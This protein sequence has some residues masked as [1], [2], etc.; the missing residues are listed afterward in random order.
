MLVS[1]NKDAHV[2]TFMRSAVAE[3]V[4]LVDIGHSPNAVS[5]GGKEYKGTNEVQRWR[6]AVSGLRDALAG[7]ESTNASP[8]FEQLKAALPENFVEDISTFISVMTNNEVQYLAD[9]SSAE[10]RELNR[11]ISTVRGAVAGVNRLYSSIRYKT[12]EDLG[13]KTIADSKGKTANGKSVL[14]GAKKFFNSQ[15]LDFFSWGHEIG[16]SG[17][18]VNEM[19]SDGYFNNTVNRV[20]ETQ[21]FMESLYKKY[22]FTNKDATKWGKETHSIDLDSGEAINLSTT[23]IMELYALSFRTQAIHHIL[24]GGIKSET[25]GNDAAHPY[26]ITENDLDAMFELL[27]NEQKSIIDEMQEFMSTKAAAWGNEVTQRL[28]MYDAFNEDYYW[29]IRSADESHDTKDPDKARAFNAILNSSFTKQLTP[30]ATSPIQI[31][32]AFSTFVDHC[33]QM[34]NYNGLA[35]PLQDTL[36]WLN[37]KARNDDGTVN[38]DATV[39]TALNR[40]GNKEAETYIVEFIKDLNGI[41]AKPRNIALAEKLTANAK[42]AAIAAK[43]RVV[44]QQPTSVIRA[45]A[46]IDPKY[47][48]TTKQFGVK[49]AVKEM[50]TYAPIAWWKSN[51]NYEI[52]LGQS[53]RDMIMGDANTFDQVNNLLMKPAGLADDL[54][55]SWIWNAVKQETKDT[56]KL[57]PNSPEFFE[58][59]AKRFTD[60]CN[61]TQVIDTPLH[62]SEIMRSKDSGVKQLTAFMSEPAKNYNIMYRAVLDAARKKPGATKK[63]G[64]TLGAVIAAQMVNSL[65]TALWDSA[66]KRGEDEEETFRKLFGKTWVS[67]FT[68]GINPLSNMPFFSDVWDMGVGIVKGKENVPKRMDMDSINSAIKAVES[69]FTTMFNHDESRYTTYYAVTNLA[70]QVSNI[71]GLPV[72]GVI[73]SI[74]GIVDIAFPNLIRRYKPQMKEEWQQEMLNEAKESGMKPRDFYDLYNS[75]GG[76]DLKTADKAEILANSDATT[77]QK[78]IMAK[79]ASDSMSNRLAEMERRNASDAEKERFIEW[80]GKYSA[81]ESTHES[82]RTDQLRQMLLADDSMSA[83]EKSSLYT[84]LTSDNFGAVDTRIFQNEKLANAEKKA[85]YESLN[86]EEELKRILT[87]TKLDRE[88][89]LDILDLAK[90]NGKQYD[91][92]TAE[93]LALSALDGAHYDRALK[94][95]KNGVSNA[96][97]LKYYD[98]MRKYAKDDSTLE[99]GKADVLQDLMDDNTLT[100]AQKAE[101]ETAMYETLNPKKADYKYTPR[102]Y[103][104]A[105]RFYLS[106]AG[107]TY[108][109]K[110]DL[111]IQYGI[112]INMA[113][114]YVKRWKKMGADNAGHAKDGDP[115][116][117]DCFAIMES[118]GIPKN[119]RNTLYKIMSGYLKE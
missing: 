114:E 36:K 7:T 34:A 67:N 86:N 65:V 11:I 72:N 96:A 118:I 8:E 98:V 117:K 83:E 3:L 4:N 84:A 48:A 95:E 16:D 42:R 24:H 60:V 74:E 111:A 73:S 85:I 71:F 82:P 55:W 23:E 81:L 25:K 70:K 17:E 14:D 105:N 10:L 76:A 26:K 92:S 102:D 31:G 50:Q 93:R 58:H 51:G 53:M 113:V 54:G 91:F 109:K 89:Q 110:G 45:T 49:R 29:T 57:K 15:M 47:F 21:D 112:D 32:D 20:R 64:R 30:N 37:Y 46:M 66:R 77:E 106:G 13:A 88:E 99:T 90:G 68:S 52:G 119:Q 78:V 79:R 19:V 97:Y 69:F 115:N 41:S 44:I 5:H 1:P 62:R 27:S 35:V 18:A 100:A 39:K 9:M 56:T 116:K 103:T 104:D 6:L 75:L 80:Y 28:Y 22:K 43:V 107:S 33:S 12:V 38:H 101:L 87:D 61:A 63:L 59:C 94:A 40:I 2:P 108:L